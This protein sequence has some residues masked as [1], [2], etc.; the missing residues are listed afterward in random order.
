MNTFGPKLGVFD[1]PV[2]PVAWLFT[3]Q[4][5]EALPDAPVPSV[6][7]TTTEDVPAVVGVPEINPDEALIDS[8]AGNPV[9][10]Y[11]SVWPDAESVAETC[12]LAAVPTVEVWLPGFVTVTV[13]PPPLPVPA[14]TWNSHSE[15]PN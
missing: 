11:V 10:L 9:A 7:V 6:T 13:L 14:N 4:P 8:P 1:C 12:R 15:Y 2:H 5:N 3:V